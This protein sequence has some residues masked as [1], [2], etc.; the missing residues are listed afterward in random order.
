MSD[1]RGDP[2]DALRSR[3]TSSEITLTVTADGQPF[4]SELDVDRPDGDPAPEFARRTALRPAEG[5]SQPHW[6]TPATAILD[7]HE[8]AIQADGTALP[9]VRSTHRLVI[10]RGERPSTL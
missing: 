3:T 10:Q 9:P 1:Q 7:R 4:A 6:L 2:V 8:D 5:R